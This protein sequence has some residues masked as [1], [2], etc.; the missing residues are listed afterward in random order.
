M[1]FVN[2]F[3]KSHPKAAKWIREGGLF[4]IFSYVV[5]FFKYLMLQF[6]PGMFSGYADIGWG[7]PS[8][9]ASLFGIDF[10]WNAI[11]YSV[12]QGGLAYLFAY[13]IS[14]FLGECVNFPLQRNFTFRSHGKLAPQITGYFMAWLVITIIVNSINCVWVAVAG[15]LVPDFIYNIGTTVLNGGVS[16]VVFFVVNKIIFADGQVQEQRNS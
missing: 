10:V 15:R 6:L 3:A 13:L 4:I 7:W 5:T 11:G 9:N 8:V 12:E 1:E 2:N 16:M 14:S